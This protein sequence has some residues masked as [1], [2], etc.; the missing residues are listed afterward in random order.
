MTHFTS[1]LHKLH[2]MW[3][4]CLYLYTAAM[5]NGVRKKVYIVLFISFVCNQFVKINRYFSWILP[6]KYLNYASSAFWFCNSKK[7][8]LEAAAV[9][10]SIRKAGGGKLEQEGLGVAGEPAHHPDH[11]LLR[12]VTHLGPRKLCEYIKILWIHKT[13]A[14]SPFA[15]FWISHDSPSA[16]STVLS[17][18]EAFWFH[19]A[20]ITNHH[21]PGGL[22]GRFIIFQ[23]WKSEI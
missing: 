1:V 3:P 7:C 17:S 16:P 19:N 20:V 15:L 8:T 23:F 22:Q 2:S 12:P 21:K 13:R 11:K 9:N 5:L 10:G 14:L 4:A 18:L 6:C